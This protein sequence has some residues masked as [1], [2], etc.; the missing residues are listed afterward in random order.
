MSIQLTEAKRLVQAEVRVAVPPFQPL[1][2]VIETE[3][4]ERIAVV[5]GVVV[6]VMISTPLWLLAGFT[7]YMLF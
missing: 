7:V 3:E 4:H 5:R 2:E 1:C 6:A